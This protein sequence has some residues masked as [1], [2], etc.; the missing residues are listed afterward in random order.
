MARPANAARGPG[1]GGEPVGDDDGVA[2]FGLN[3][4]DVPG[5]ADA[6]AGQ[7]GGPGP[8]PLPG[9]PAVQVGDVQG[10]F[11]DGQE[12]ARGSS[13]TPGV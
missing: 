10:E 1:G 2:G 6:Q 7:G 12:Q 9:G 5:D 3:V 4:A 13:P 8:D 11:A